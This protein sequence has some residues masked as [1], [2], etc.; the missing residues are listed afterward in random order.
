MPACWGNCAPVPALHRIR[1]TWSLSFCVL[2]N[3]AC[4]SSQCANVFRLLPPLLWPPMLTRWPLL[5]SWSTF[6]GGSGRSRRTTTPWSTSAS[7]RSTTADSRA[8]APASSWVPLIQWQVYAKKDETAT[9]YPPQTVDFCFASE[10]NLPLLWC[11]HVC[12]VKWCLVCTSST[13]VLLTRT[14]CVHRG[15]WQRAVELHS[16]TN[17]LRVA[18]ADRAEVRLPSVS[19]Q[20]RR[21][22]VR[23]SLDGCVPRLSP[24]FLHTNAIALNKNCRTTNSLSCGKR[25]DLKGGAVHWAAKSF[26]WIS[27]MFWFWSQLNRCR[28]QRIS[29]M[30]T[31]K[32]D[33]GPSPFWLV[34]VCCSPEGAQRGHVFVG[35]VVHRGHECDSSHVPPAAHQLHPPP[36]QRQGSCCRFSRPWESKS[37]HLFVSNCRVWHE[38]V[39]TLTSGIIHYERNATERSRHCVESLSVRQWCGA[40]RW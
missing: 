38:S 16:S 25:N 7:A 21:N 32:C 8:W 39:A 33:L 22:R 15:L 11:A 12:C 3:L 37:R 24:A 31:T 1:D 6:G 26:L 2:P 19:S 18:G 10:L 4:V 20:H 13:L 35:A 28:N 27:K 29:G 5:C 40:S 14:L 36:L 9:W 23:E 34:P 30:R 17:F